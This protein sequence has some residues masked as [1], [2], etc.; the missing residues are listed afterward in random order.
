MFGFGEAVAQLNAGV[1]VARS[2]WNGKGMF[3]FLVSGNSWD[4]TTD[5]EGVDGL[6]TLPF[7]CMKTADGKLVP[8][9]ASQTDIIATDWVVV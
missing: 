4:F 1:K 5:V 2:G 3:L 9:L 6:D 8:W 7:V